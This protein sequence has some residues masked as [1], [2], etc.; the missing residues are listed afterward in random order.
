MRAIANITNP[1]PH[2]FLMSRTCWKG[3]EIVEV[4]RASPSPLPCLWALLDSCLVCFWN[5]H[6]LHHL[7]NDFILFRTFAW[8]PF[9][10]TYYCKV[11]FSA[12]KDFV[13][14]IFSFVYILIILEFA[15][16]KIYYAIPLLVTRILLCVV[17]NNIAKLRHQ[18]NKRTVL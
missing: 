16:M 15:Y 14:F 10:V 2:V 5:F 1:N 4:I 13:F 12:G 6:C 11:L 8:R 9:S 18:T 7:H 17:D 3:E